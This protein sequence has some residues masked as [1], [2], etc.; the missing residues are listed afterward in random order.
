MYLLDSGI[1]YNVA[2]SETKV[3]MIKQAQLS[4][5]HEYFSIIH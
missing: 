3:Q 1:L 2:D 4:S 5:N